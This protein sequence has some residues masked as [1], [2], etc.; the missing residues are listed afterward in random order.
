M[1]EKSLDPKSLDFC[2]KVN[3]LSKDKEALKTSMLAAIR[4]K[5]R[6]LDPD[7]ASNL[8]VGGEGGG[9]GGAQRRGPGGPSQGIIGDG[10]GTRH[11]GR[12]PAAPP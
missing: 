3:R 7:V 12:T 8:A 9:K 1:E 2:W 5:P 10:R 4:K 6:P 11:A